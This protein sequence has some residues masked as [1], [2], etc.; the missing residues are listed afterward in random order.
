MVDNLSNYDSAEEN[1][2]YICD[3]EQFRMGKMLFATKYGMIKKWTERNFVVSKKNNYRNETA[4]R[5]RSGFYTACKM[6][7]KILSYRQRE[8]ISFDFW[9][10]KLPRRKRYSNRVQ[11]K[12]QKTDILENVYLF[13][14]GTE[15]KVPYREKEVTLNHLKLAKR[16][17][18]WGQRQR[19]YFKTPCFY[20]KQV[21]YCKLVT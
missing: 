7:T 3:E 10:R 6:K 11:N 15:I 18:E 12:L 14:E 17:I 19:G 5:G 4:G 8:D 21:L 13:E 16:D 1:I 2:I 20:M 9:Q